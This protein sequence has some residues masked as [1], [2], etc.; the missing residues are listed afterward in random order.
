MTQTIDEIAG[1]S[2]DGRDI[3]IT[4]HRASV[5]RAYGDLAA[6]KRFDE[7]RELSK[8]TGISPL[9]VIRLV[10]Q[11]ERRSGNGKE[12][13]TIYRLCSGQEIQERVAVGQ[14]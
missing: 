12:A 14:Y 7:I 9:S 11:E 3:S 13:A 2:D 5:Q 1:M 6:Q 8:A 10:C 4:A